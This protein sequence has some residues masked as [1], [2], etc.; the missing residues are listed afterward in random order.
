MSRINLKEVIIENAK[1]QDIYELVEINKEEYWENKDQINLEELFKL[2]KWWVIPDLLK[3]HRQII[4]NCDGKILIAKYNN[5]IIS[6]LDYVISPDFTSR[7]IKRIHII[8][9][10]VRRD[11]RNIGI[12][13]L[14]LENL[15]T[16]FP[17]IEIWV[18]AEDVRSLALYSSLGEKRRNITNWTLKFENFK[19]NKIIH[20]DV[21]RIEVINYNDLMIDVQNSKLYPVIG[22][23]YA[24][25][26]DLEQLRSSDEVNQYIWG[27]TD[28]SIIQVYQYKSLKI[29]VI[30]TQYLRIYVPDSNFSRF[31]FRLILSQIMKDIFESG[32]DEIY[33]QTY[34]EDNV[35]DPLREIGFSLDDNTDYVFRL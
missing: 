25:I 21:K 1:I 10:I 31:G 7:K 3:W 14:L 29:V 35:Q 8:W 6:E 11:Y 4:D 27:N 19:M 32:F 9:L 23:Y 12:A 20:K 30:L 13:K 15:K 26:F 2:G 28:K 24:P 17:N 34:S 33:A 5:E 18:E 22:R 16:N